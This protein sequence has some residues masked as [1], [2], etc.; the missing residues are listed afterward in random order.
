MTGSDPASQNKN[1]STSSP[2]AA[3]H[4]QSAT[5]LTSAPAGHQGGVGAEEKKNISTEEKS[6]LSAENA[7]NAENAI[8]AAEASQQPTREYL[9]GWRLYTLIFAYVMIPPYPAS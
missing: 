3:S 8:P 6:D 9:K 5:I 1:M 7:E 2:T 4:G